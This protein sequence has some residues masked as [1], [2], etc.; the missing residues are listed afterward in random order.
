MHFIRQYLN[1]MAEVF[2]ESLLGAKV[3][4]TPEASSCR[5]AP[6]ED[7]RPKQQLT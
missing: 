6:A 1:N 2:C 4:L 3:V 7:Q 5:E